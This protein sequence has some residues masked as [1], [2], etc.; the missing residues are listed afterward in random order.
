MYVDRRSEEEQPGRAGL[1]P[2][3]TIRALFALVTISALAFVVIGTAFRGQYWAWGVTMG[4]VSLIVTS[5][6]HAA[7]F[8]VIW[9]FAQMPSAQPATR[10]ATATINPLSSPGPAADESDRPIDS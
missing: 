10:P 5:L 7:W 3:F 2:R 8:G 6:V 4:L 9:L 1:M